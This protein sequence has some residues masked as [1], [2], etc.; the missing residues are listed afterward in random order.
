M[1]WLIVKELFIKLIPLK[2]YEPQT[3]RKVALFMESRNQILFKLTGGSIRS[4]P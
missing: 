2:S 1:M 3:C 4:D